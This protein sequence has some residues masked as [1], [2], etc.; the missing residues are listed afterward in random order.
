MTFDEMQEIYLREK[1]KIAQEARERA[2]QAAK[3]AQ[4]QGGWN[5]PA[6]IQVNPHFIP[7]QPRRCCGSPRV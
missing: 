5:R 4:Q 2:A 6:M 7:L 1:Q 3:E